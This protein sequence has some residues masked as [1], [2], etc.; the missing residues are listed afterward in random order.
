MPARILVTRP[1][2]A[3]TAQIVVDGKPIGEL[4][5]VS[6]GCLFRPP[7]PLGVGI[8]PDARR[9]SHEAPGGGPFAFVRR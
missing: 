7:P 2:A 6:D 4:A 8:Q 3:T 1:V 5:A 9:G